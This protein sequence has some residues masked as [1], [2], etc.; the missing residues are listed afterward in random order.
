MAPGKTLGPSKILTFAGVELD[1]IHCESPLHADKLLICSQMIASF[2]KKKKATLRELQQLTGV[3]HFACS[4]VVPGCA[5]L[6][7]LINY[8]FIY[9]YIIYNTLFVR[10]N[11]VLGWGVPLL[12]KVF[13]SVCPHLRRQYI[14]VFNQKFVY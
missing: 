14:H 4:V 1:T 9:F 5:F 10:M 13:G 8:A 12:C 3:L 6:R 7:R 2:L 11:F